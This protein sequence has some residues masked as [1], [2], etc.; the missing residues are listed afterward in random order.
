[1]VDAAYDVE[2]MTDFGV[3]ALERWPPLTST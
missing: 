2:A 3:E 1:V